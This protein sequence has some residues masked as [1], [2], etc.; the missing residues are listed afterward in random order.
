MNNYLNHKVLKNLEFVFKQ[1]EDHELIPKDQYSFTDNDGELVISFEYFCFKTVNS[2]ISQEKYIEMKDKIVN[3]V[4]EVA[5]HLL[6]Y[7]TFTKVIL[8][9]YEILEDGTKY[10][11]IKED[12]F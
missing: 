11:E 8:Q 2:P 4:R 6:Q 10:L 3:Y 7:E 1:Y 12:F 5:K 9:Q